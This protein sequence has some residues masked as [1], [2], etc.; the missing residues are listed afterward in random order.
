MKFF[1]PE[2]FEFNYMGLKDW[3]I[4]AK[5]ISDCAN[6][7]LEREG[8]RIYKSSYD[9]WRTERIGKDDFFRGPLS[10][11]R[12]I[13]INIEP[14]EKCTHPPEKVES[15][16]YDPAEYTYTYNCSCGAR[17]EPSGFSEVKE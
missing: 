14:I 2:D 10:T 5:R 9:I 7:K 15:T 6:A 13:L 17:V 8:K 12:A 11:H 16:K 1:T 4:Y 3:P